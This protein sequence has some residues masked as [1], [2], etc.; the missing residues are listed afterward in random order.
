[1]I[2]G[3]PGTG[4]T[5][6]VARIVALLAE[7]PGPPPHVALAAPTAK[8]ANRLREAV[9]E[10]ARELDV[11]PGVRALLEGLDATTL[12]RLLGRRPGSDSRFRHHRGNRL[13]H[14]AIVVDETSMV[15]LSLM[16]RLLEAVRPEARLVLV[17]DPAQLSSIEAGAVLGDI[18]GPATGEASSCSSA[19]TA[20]A[21]G[22]TTWPPPCGPATPTPCCTR[23][24]ARR[25]ASPGS[26][27]RTSARCA[28]PPS[29]AGG[30]LFEAGRAGDDEAALKALDAFRVLCAHRHG[31][32]GVA[33]WTRAVE[34]WL[35]DAVPG[36]GAEARWYAGR[37]LLVTKNDY[38]LG[39]FNG[40][41]GVVVAGERRSAGG[42]VPARRGGRAVQPGAPRGG[43]DRL[44]DD[45]PQG[46]GLAVRHR[47]GAA[48]GPGLAPAHARAALHGDHPRARGAD[49]GRLRGGDPRGG[50]AADRRARRA[51]ENGCGGPA[52]RPAPHEML[53]VDSP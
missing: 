29:A 14:D 1:M 40:D 16:A 11:D 24:R 44:R 53:L 19:S 30:A 7:Q 49:P 46:P 8:A 50:G 36:Y 9:Q 21:A 28:T 33:T 2:A 38:G 10:E 12:H 51:C 32:S 31:P 41:A 13:P 5:T 18:V 45:G 37:P 17:G 26:T 42:G 15:S 25:R 23:W 39:L 4:K 22:S 6:T 3:G 43:R 47:G 20:T 34:G 35:A 48:A 27:A 52:L